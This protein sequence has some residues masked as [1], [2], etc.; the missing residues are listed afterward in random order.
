MVWDGASKRRDAKTFNLAQKQRRD[1]PKD[2]FLYQ[3]KEA[4]PPRGALL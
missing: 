4:E 2:S 1:L 3:S